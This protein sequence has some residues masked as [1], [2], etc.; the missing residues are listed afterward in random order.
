MKI[1]ITNLYGQSPYSV[2]LMAQNMVAEISRSLGFKEIGVYSFNADNESVRDLSIRFDGMNAAI[3]NGD[4]VI[5]QSPTWN[6]SHFD[7]EY[8]K[9]LKIYN[10]LKVIIFIHDVVPLMFKYNYFLIEKTIE[11]YNLADLL[12]VP[13]EKMIDVLKN[14]GLKVNNFVVQN[15]WDHTANLYLEKPKFK[16]IINFAGNPDRFEFLNSWDKE[17][18]ISIYTDK[19]K[20]DSS[21]NVEYKGWYFS[22]ELLINLNQNGGFGLVWNQ[23]VDSEYYDINVSYKLSTYIAAGL[24]VIVPKTL[25]NADIILK[26]NLGFVVDSLEEA[27]EKVKNI[28]EH[29]YSELLNNVWKFRSL[30]VD[31][32]ISK[33][34]LMEAVFKVLMN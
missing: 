14:E 9:R 26:N 19:I 3:S 13:S 34:N 32:L 20:E 24:P 11:M 6:G 25:S 17:V 33:R 5:F 18:K 15:M 21:A 4:I 31:G 29:E 30:V 2:A 28:S 16:K 22:N 12:I 7:L 27:A 10:N 8:I 1:H 23:T